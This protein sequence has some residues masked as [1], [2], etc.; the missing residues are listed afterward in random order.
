MLLA[1]KSEKI[2]KLYMG[3]IAFID[4]DFISSLNCLSL[5]IRLKFNQGSKAII[6]LNNRGNNKHYNLFYICYYLIK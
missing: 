6:K 1:F 2:T 4:L 5:Y 3:F